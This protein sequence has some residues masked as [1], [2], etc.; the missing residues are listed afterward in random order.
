MPLRR[1]VLDTGLGFP[2]ALSFGKIPEW[3]NLREQSS[4][5]TKR[6]KRTEVSQ[7]P[8]QARGDG[9]L[10][11]G[12]AGPSVSPAG[13]HLPI[14]SRWGERVGSIISPMTCIGEVAVAQQLTEGPY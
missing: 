8:C 7:A 5:A 2:C 12:V 3:L 4:L 1:P 14:A 10:K 9:C 11:A 6:R 13:C